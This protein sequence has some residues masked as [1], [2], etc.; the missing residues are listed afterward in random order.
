MTT[1]TPT[2]EPERQP[3]PRQ[4]DPW[5]LQPG[6]P[7]EA[8]AAFVEYRDMG[9][10]RSLAILA[11][12]AVKPGQNRGKSLSL[13]EEWSSRFKWQMRIRA[14]ISEEDRIRREANLELLIELQRRHLHV[15]RTMLDHVTKQLE[16]LDPEALKPSDLIRWFEVA[17]K[18][19]RLTLGEETD[20]VRQKFAQMSDEDLIEYLRHN[21]PVGSLPPA[22]LSLEGEASEQ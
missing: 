18:V 15:A 21:M 5:E 6:E 11:N 8:Y 1:S 19:E 10:G 16:T 14:W 22:P 9:A 2:T 12:Q 20:I 3:D 4:P 13:L 17:V 7:P